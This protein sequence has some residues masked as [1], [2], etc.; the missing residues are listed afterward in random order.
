MIAGGVIFLLALLSGNFWSTFV[1]L[2]GAELVAYFLIRGSRGK[3]AQEDKRGSLSIDARSEPTLA[4]LIGTKS[5]LPAPPRS[6]SAHT[7]I[8]PASATAPHA[9]RSRPAADE[10]YSAGRSSNPTTP[11]Y[12]LPKAPKEVGTGQWVP[13]GEAVCVANVTLPGGMVY[14]GAQ[15][16]APNG[17]T[18]PCLINGLLPVASAGDC[19]TRQM[20]YWPSYAEASPSER[21]AYLTWL[22]EGRSAPDCD[23]GYVF[24]FYYGLERRIIVDSSR[25]DAAKGDWL[26]IVRELRRLLAI[27]GEK[28]GSFRHYAGK[29]LSWIEL[30]GTPRGL[31]EKPVPEFPRSYELPPY[32]RLALGQASADRAPVPAPLAL[33]W[34]R[35]APDYGLRTAAT[36]CPEEF[37]RLF[38]TRYL[39]DFG[40]G[41]VLPKNRTKLRFV[42]RAAS[43]GLMGTT[44][45]MEFGDVPDVSALTRPIKTLTA[46]A[47]RCTDQLASY[48]RLRGR[49]PSLVD[50]LECR[51]LLPAAAWPTEDRTKLDALIARVQSA[52][53]MLTLR[54]LEASLGGAGQPLTRKG[55]RNLAQFLEAVDVG[56]EP[57]VLC[58]A[59]TPQPGGNIVLFGQLA[60]DAKVGGGAEYQTAALTLQMG[61]ALAMADGKFDEREMKF[62]RGKI[63]EWERLT[64]AERRRLHAHLQLLLADPPTLTGLKKKLEPLSMA[65]RK[66]IA[67]MMVTLARSDG[68]VSPDEV[69]LLEKIYKALGIEPQRVFGDVHAAGTGGDLASATK[70]PESGIHLDADRIAVLQQDTA[71]VSA[72]LTEIFTEE[73]DQEPEESAEAPSNDQPT[74]LPGL[75]EP[76]AAFARLLLTRP[77]WARTELED[78]AADLGLMLDGALEQINESAFDVLDAPLCEGDDPIDV[79]TELLEKIEA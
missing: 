33:A 58:G 10:F 38:T 54:E 9:S 69:T 5:G 17:R 41:L 70:E 1:I 43:A 20:G 66:S 36:R 79:D 52:A 26:A 22:S 67:A 4:E 16:D 8:P 51:V 30:D 12:V 56:M 19:R 13:P 2:S 21:R 44:V 77:Q 57:N 59:R 31:Y 11:N 65:A 18:D 25:E 49:N 3:Q 48:S 76:H 78:A 14:V 75:D 24:L 29:L 15:L 42:Y 7:G 35:L 74:L 32:V 60:R 27:Y 6:S 37:G 73:L 53:V 68:F 50:S 64:L 63:D 46:L 61:S 47:D 45:S 28:S 34:V 71:R 23:I 40:P 62:L 72:L 39:D 55:V